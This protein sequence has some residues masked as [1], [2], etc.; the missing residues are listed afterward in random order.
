M[1]ILC[2]GYMVNWLQGHND[3]G[4]KALIC[5]DGVFS[6]TQ[7]W[8]S[9]EEFVSSYSLGRNT[10][11]GKAGSG[12]R[13]VKTTTGRRSMGMPS[14]TSGIQGIIS[15]TGRLRSL[16]FMAARFVAGSLCR[17]DK[18][19][20]STNRTIGYPRRKALESSTPCS[21]STLLQLLT[22]WSSLEQVWAF[23]HVSSTLRLKTIGCWIRSTAPLGTRRFLRC[24]PSRLMLECTQSK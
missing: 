21:V 8:Y 3:V 11:D 4:F 1:S 15:R 12:F 22:E 24:V 10:A 23:L 18:D 5:H 7:V 2:T 17:I 19:V 14:T 16:S 9:T 20:S 13:S 6:T